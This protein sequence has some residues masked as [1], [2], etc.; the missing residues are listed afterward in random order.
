MRLIL[1]D[2]IAS[3]REEGELDSLLTD[4][5]F[6]K[7]IIPQTKTTKGARQ[8]G[9]DIEA[10]GRDESGKSHLFIVTVKRGDIDRDSWDG[11]KNA[12]RQSLDQIRETHLRLLPSKL[13]R[14]PCTIIVT[15]NGE[16][17]QTVD[18]DWKG[19]V[20]ANSNDGL[21]FEF[22]GLRKITDE[23]DENIVTN[24]TF[25]WADM[26]LFRKA[27][28]L[29]E[30]IDYDLLHFDLF[31]QKLLQKR[32]SIS[33]TIKI[34]RFINLLQNIIYKWCVA[35]NNLKNSYL[36]SELVVL[37]LTDY[38]LVN[39]LDQN[40][41]IRIEYSKLFTSQVN[42]A[43]E[44]IKKVQPQY[45]VEYRLGMYT[46][47][48]GCD[49]PLLC[50]EQLGIVAAVGH[51]LLYLQN[52]YGVQD[53]EVQKKVVFVGN[54]INELLVNNPA[55]HFPQFDDHLIEISMVLEFMFL[56]CQFDAGG[57]YIKNII[58]KL[59]EAY[60]FFHK[61]IPLFRADHEVLMKVWASSKSV[62]V[63]SSHLVLMLAEWTLIFGYLE[64]YNRIRMA[65]QR[66][67]AYE[68][69]NLQ[70]WIPD[71]ETETSYYGKNVM[72]ESGK[73][74]TSI[75]LPEK[76]KDFI[77]LIK[78]QAELF[79]TEIELNKYAKASFLPYLASRRF[80]NLPFPQQWRRLIYKT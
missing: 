34:I 19:Y 61:F 72:H 32:L 80:R 68:N 74:I 23:I 21:D 3:L 36:A 14:L 44:Y 10:L 31:L 62:E 6:S 39:G 57:M 8:R 9:V 37:R 79:F 63:N 13:K 54:C 71:S 52:V 7:K 38:I 56:T 33:N 5:L 53:P 22:W 67:M 4:L 64:G 42:L 46:Q 69:L 30:E 2:Y 1:N 55:A 16:M 20:E 73:V 29:I 17:R 75:Q 58:T 26:S 41:Q 25:Q 48:V 49:Y 28:A 76:Y 47:S 51:Q 50:F 77:N 24:T 27:L 78:D 40:K 15:T 66:N 43:Y 11:D 60:R 59:A 45:S 12:I 70:V 65:C 18:E 35:Q